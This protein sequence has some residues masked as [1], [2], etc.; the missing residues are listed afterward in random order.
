MHLCMDWRS[1]AFDWNRVRAFLVTAEEGSFSAAGRSLGLTQPTVGRQVSAL[2]SELEVTLFERVGS[3][4]QLTESGLELLEHARAMGVA[5]TS[6]SLTASG[7]T[8]RVDGTVR[9]TA[10]QLISAYL[11][12]PIIRTLQR[13]HPGIR[14]EIAASNTVQDLRRREADI[15][16]RNGMPDQPELVAKRL[17]DASAQPYASVQYLASFGGAMAPADFAQVKVLGFEN[18]VRMIQGLHALGLPVSEDNFVLVT[19]DHLVQ[20]QMARQG[21]GVCL[22][23][24]QVG[25]ADPLMRPALKDFSGIPLPMWLVTHREVRTSRRVRIVFDALAQG[26]SAR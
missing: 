24:D 18:Q 26:L 6:L 22:V 17:T 15:A 21:L 11:L 10:S 8:T 19:D 13:T 5:A 25:E 4:L 3:S 20:W 12:P 2:E 9:I 1:V 7:Q 14:I 16:I 23:M